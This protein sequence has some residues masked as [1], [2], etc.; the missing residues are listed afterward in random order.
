[1]SIHIA[2]SL[3]YTAE[4]NTTLQSNHILIK[5]NY[6]GMKILI[7]KP[8]W[9]NTEKSWEFRVTLGDVKVI[10]LLY[11]IS[12][13][14]PHITD[15]AHHLHYRYHPV[16]SLAESLWQLQA[17]WQ[18]GM[19]FFGKFPLAFQVILLSPSE[20]STSPAID[21]RHITQ[22]DQS[23]KMYLPHCWTAQEGFT[24]VLSDRLTWMSLL[25]FDPKL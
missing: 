7:T 19:V 25:H 13:S 16:S 21:G 8:K 4:S 17:G 14:Q 6:L 11:Y 18:S 20:S 12:I 1:M 9:F 15:E 22:D 24:Q 2:D 10:S 3:C 5:K 23:K